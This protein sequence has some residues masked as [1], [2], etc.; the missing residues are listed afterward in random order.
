MVAKD[1][2]RPKRRGHDEG[3]GLVP[4]SI[5]PA[6]VR[7]IHPPRNQPD[8]PQC[9]VV[10]EPRPR[11][12]KRPYAPDVTGK[13][14]NCKDTLARQELPAG[15][16]LCLRFSVITQSFSALLLVYSQIHATPST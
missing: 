12:R 1:P 10:P 16:R 5:P 7:H 4:Q 2:V 6:R 14:I 11:P 13:L 15:P 9:H 3:I 8:P